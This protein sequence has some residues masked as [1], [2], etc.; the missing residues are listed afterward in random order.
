MNEILHANIFFVIASVGTVIFIIIV[1]LILW[2][3]FKM[4]QTLRLIIERIERA[5]DIISHDVMEFRSSVKTGFVGNLIKWF[6][7]K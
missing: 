3:I 2:Q 4:V 1:S 5:S 7:N 6:M